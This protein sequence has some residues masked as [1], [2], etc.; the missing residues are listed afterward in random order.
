M[1][2]NFMVSSPVQVLARML[3]WNA[4]QGDALQNGS[5]LDMAEAELGVLSSH[6]RIATIGC[7]LNATPAHLCLLTSHC[8]RDVFFQLQPAE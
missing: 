7:P 3:S 5:W 6:C 8:F 2:L 1:V 4:A